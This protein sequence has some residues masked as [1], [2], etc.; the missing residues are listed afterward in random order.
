MSASWKRVAG[1]MFLTTILGCGAA[2]RFDDA[3]LTSG[4]DPLEIDAVYALK[5]NLQRAAQTGLEAALAKY[6]S[7]DNLQGQWRIHL[8]KTKLALGRGDVQV[9][10]LESQ[11]LQAITDLLDTAFT[12][13]NTD[14]LLGRIRADPS[15]FESALHLAATP[16]QRAVALTYLD[17]ILEAIEL[18]DLNE[19]DYP[20][21]RAFVTY[22]YGLQVGSRSTLQRALSLYKM[23]ADPRG[24]ADTLMSLANLTTSRNRQEG[25]E[26]AQRALRVLSAIGDEGRSEAVR[27]WID[28]Q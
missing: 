24:V 17:R 19:T 14:I 27:A 22:K 26:Y 9:A 6:Q 20:T 23:A 12:S 7:L 3:V 21:D 8:M 15:Y 16:M 10:D 5:L 4:I 11:R 2:A 1:A 13:Y 25:R 28:S 18:I